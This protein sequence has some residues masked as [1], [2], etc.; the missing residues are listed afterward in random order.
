M[1]TNLIVVDFDNTLIPFDSFR[2]FVFFWMKHIPIFTGIILLLRLFRLLGVADFKKMLILSV[3]KRKYFTFQNIVFSDFLFKSIDS[4]VVQKIRNEAR[5]NTTILLLSASPDLYINKVGEKLGFKAK[6]SYFN[7]NNQFIH[8]FGFQK[9]E[10][11]RN[12]FPEEQY[13]Y[14]YAI[15]DSFTDLEMLKLFKKYDLVK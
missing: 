9:I 15:S 1:R 6:G 14:L 5:D 12:E 7:S 3:R 4:E 11:L 13:C 10:Y 2:R 8:L